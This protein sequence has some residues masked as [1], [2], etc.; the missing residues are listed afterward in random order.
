MNCLGFN[1]VRY[2]EIFVLLVDIILNILVTKQFST[3]Q[4]INNLGRHYCLAYNLIQVLYL[5]IY[6]LL[7]FTN[8]KI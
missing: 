2:Y 5:Q 3:F 4:F 8:S 6:A 1:M 7:Y